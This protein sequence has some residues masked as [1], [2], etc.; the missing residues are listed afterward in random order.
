MPELPRKT[1]HPDPRA[2]R[3]STR[4]SSLSDPHDP[5]RDRDPREPLDGPPA[6]HDPDDDPDA[7][8]PP[9]PP[10]EDPIDAPGVGEPARRDPD[11]HEPP[12]EVGPRLTPGYQPIGRGAAGCQSD[13]ARKVQ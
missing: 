13:K 9:E 10:V 8:L 7:G 4:Q 12:R 3:R 5:R 11:P 6:R 2:S 1:P